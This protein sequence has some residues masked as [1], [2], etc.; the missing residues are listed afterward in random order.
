[1]LH[2]NRVIIPIVMATFLAV[3][4]IGL[5][6]R[7]DSAVTGQIDSVSTGATANGQQG[8]NRAD[9]DGG[10][11]GR[12][13]PR[14]TSTEQGSS[15]P[16]AGR[17]PTSRTAS[18]GVTSSSTTRAPDSTTAS[19]SPSSVTSSTTSPTVTVR[20]TVTL[21]PPP[22]ATIAPTVTVEPDPTITI[23]LPTV[24]LPTITFDEG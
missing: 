2:P 4:A 20:P 14:S 21:G 7:N 13:V 1:M 8:S 9:D 22:T 10:N 6:V 12:N 23:S 15:P 16:G 19:S 18:T 5:V 3:A 11:V 24:S 17:S